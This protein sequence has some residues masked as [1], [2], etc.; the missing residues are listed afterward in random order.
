[1]GVDSYDIA[2]F[3]LPLF[4]GLVQVSECALRVECKVMLNRAVGFSWRQWAS[5]VHSAL[6]TSPMADCS[7]SV[8]N[9]F[10]Q[11]FIKTSF[12]TY[13]FYTHLSWNI[14]DQNNSAYL[15][16][17]FR[18]V[19]S[20][21]SILHMRRSHWSLPR[22]GRIPRESLPFSSKRWDVILYNA[23]KRWKWIRLVH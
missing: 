2:L 7:P 18:S 10:V 13:L 16:D 14:F 15:V 23:Y 4:S 6:D 1:M 22:W 20:A 5:G 21:T 11:V 12:S 8:E 3:L 19:V 17:N 9:W